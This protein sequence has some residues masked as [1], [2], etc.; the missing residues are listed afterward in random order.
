MGILVT[1]G[2]VLMG[3]GDWGAVEKEVLVGLVSAVDDLLVLDNDTVTV[4]MGERGSGVLVGDD[5]GEPD[6][7]GLA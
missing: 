3:S 1:E 6:M 2:I 5:G 4:D 7:P